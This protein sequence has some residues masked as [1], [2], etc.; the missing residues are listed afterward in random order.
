MATL[1]HAIALA[2]Q[3]HETQTDKAG[4]P[5]IL[6]PLR[7]MFKMSSETE[8]AAAVFHDVVEDTD[9]TLEGLRAEGYAEDVLAA[10]DALTHRDG[11]DYE[12]YLA[13]VSA[14]PTAR[15]VKL[16]DLED[17]MDVRRL[18]VLTDKDI[19]RLQ[20][21]HRVWNEWKSLPED[22]GTQTIV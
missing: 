1:A 16:A 2:A 15:K 6:H 18:S 14:N 3:A 17:N 12:T 13:R 8:M 11:E 9:W 22:G 4:A 20:K 5:Y 10:V 21:Y 19:T 7:L